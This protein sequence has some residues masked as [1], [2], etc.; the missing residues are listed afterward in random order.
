MEF[1]P[2]GS[3]RQFGTPSS[4]NLPPRLILRMAFEIASA[5]VH[6]HELPSGKRLIH[7]DLKPENVLLTADFHCKIADFG[8]AELQALTGSATATNKKTTKLDMTLAYA[9]PEKLM[10]LN[11]KPRRE[12][13]VYSFG[14]LL[15]VLLNRKLPYQNTAQESAFIEMIKNGR[16]P[17]FDSLHSF[18]E[19]FENTNLEDAANFNS[20]NAFLMQELESIVKQCWQQNPSDRPSMCEV[21]DRMERLQHQQLDANDQE[22][23]INVSPTFTSSF[24]IP[25]DQQLVGL[26]Y[27]SPTDGAFA[28]GT[29]DKHFLSSKY[30]RIF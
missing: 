8:S 15:Y 14:M 2:A 18:M 12:H 20:N 6:M 10:S 23:T 3:L 27:F 21:R 5:L 30:P 29:F 24:I 17:E 13:D 26:Q 28:A 16:R 4:G 1:L 19:A 7:G 9:A 25:D 11:S 22:Q